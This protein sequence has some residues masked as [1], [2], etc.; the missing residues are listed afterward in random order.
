MHTRSMLSLT[1]LLVS[2]EAMSGCAAAS[3]GSSDTAARPDSARVRH[4][5][6]YLASDA[7]EGRGTGTPGN[8]SAAAYA[9]RR[10]A[11]LG[12]RPFSPDYLQRF[13]GAVGDARALG[14]FGRGAD[15]E[16]RR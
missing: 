8:D 7:L 10:F 14:R 13:S 5:I 9:A 12:L 11:S 6:E 1:I 15:A 4:D 3:R 16:H 2:A